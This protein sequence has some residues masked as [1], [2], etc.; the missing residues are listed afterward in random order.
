MPAIVALPESS[1][2]RV[3]RMRTAVLLPAPFGPSRPW[4][5]PDST[6]IVK[7]SRAWVAP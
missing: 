6:A 3:A 4:M 5:V 1:L 7:P 2:V